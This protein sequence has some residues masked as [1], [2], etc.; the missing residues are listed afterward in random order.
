MI[1]LCLFNLAFIE[2]TL[3]LFIKFGMFAD[4]FRKSVC[5]PYLL[6]SG[7]LIIHILDHWN[8]SL[9]SETQGI[10]LLC[11][12]C[13]LS[14]LHFVQGLLLC[15]QVHWS[16]FYTVK[17]AVISSSVFFH[18]RCFFHQYS[19]H[20]YIQ[21]LSASSLCFSFTPLNIRNKFIMAVFMSFLL[22]LSFLSLLGPLLID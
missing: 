19:S 17:S 18:F 8:R 7:S 3:W 4:F 14:E 2:L 9:I 5:L 1:F 12:V 16:F 6:L 15:F 13:F 10:L 20:F 22:I 11:L 21:F